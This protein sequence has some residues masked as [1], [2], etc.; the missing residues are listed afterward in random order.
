[1]KELTFQQ[2]SKKI[3]KYK[4]NTALFI[5]ANNDLIRKDD[6]YYEELYKMKAEKE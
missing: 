2:S 3:A 5:E 1:M 4:H 6:F